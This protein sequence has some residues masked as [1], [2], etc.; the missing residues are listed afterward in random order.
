MKA[1]EEV[2][3]ECTGTQFWKVYVAGAAWYIVCNKDVSYTVRGVGMLV[4][5]CICMCPVSACVR[6]F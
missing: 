2:K 5:L 4:I 1:F 6:L 3:K